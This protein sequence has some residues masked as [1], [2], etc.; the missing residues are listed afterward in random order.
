[1][2]TIPQL[3]KAVRLKAK[4]LDRAHGTKYYRLKADRLNGQ[5]AE[6]NEFQAKA[7]SMIVD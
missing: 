2:E 3:A 5:V 1:V 6:S 4:G 7:S